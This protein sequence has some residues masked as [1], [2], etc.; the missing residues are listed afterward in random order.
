M[1]ATSLPN[2][3]TIYMPKSRRSVF[4]PHAKVIRDITG[5]ITAAE[6]RG[7]WL[8]AE[9]IPVE[10]EVLLIH[11]AYSADWIVRHDVER[12]ILRGVQALLDAGEKAVMVEFNGGAV[13]YEADE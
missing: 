11:V 8:D 1:K 2:K 6:A 7:A 10:E 9:H 4:L 12:A 5:G 13:I 3:A